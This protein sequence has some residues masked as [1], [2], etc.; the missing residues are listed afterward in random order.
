MTNNAE[1]EA[2]EKW[3]LTQEDFCDL[4]C[5][6]NGAY[7]SIIT[8]RTWKAW[9][10]RAQASGMPIEYTEAIGR[11]GGLYHAKF[12]QAHPLPATWRWQELWEAMLAAGPT[13][14]KSAS[15]PVERLEALFEKWSWHADMAH[16]V[17]ELIAEYK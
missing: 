6:S 14:P 12:R 7:L 15:V 1:R 3:V 4:A 5:D 16:D 11:A 10:A 9:Q 2:F 13:P 8:E 17:A